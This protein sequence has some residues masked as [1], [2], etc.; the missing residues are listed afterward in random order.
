[1]LDIVWPDDDLLV[2]SGGAPLSLVDNHSA[3]LLN[4][5][6][7]YTLQLTSSVKGWLFQYR[8]GFD[9][10]AINVSSQQPQ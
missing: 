4:N 5:D 9:F 7:K 8:Q 10:I 6:K 2:V 1:M 3:T